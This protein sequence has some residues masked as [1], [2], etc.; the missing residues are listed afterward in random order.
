MEIKYIKNSNAFFPTSVVIIFGEKCQSYSC[1]FL[2]YYQRKK[3]R[4]QPPGKLHF[5]F[6]FI[7]GPLHCSLTETEPL[8]SAD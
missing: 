6:L 8:I 1:L 3:Q 5:F 4:K 7:S 2:D